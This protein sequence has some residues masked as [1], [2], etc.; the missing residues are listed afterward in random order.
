[1]IAFLVGIILF[2]VVLVWRMCR[3]SADADRQMDAVFQSMIQKK[4]VSFHAG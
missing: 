4:E 2:V 1:M 3:V